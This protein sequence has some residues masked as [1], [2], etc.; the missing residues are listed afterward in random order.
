MT[1]FRYQDLSRNTSLDRQ[2]V[3]NPPERIAGKVNHR[4]DKA[5]IHRLENDVK[6]L[7]RQL[8]ELAA[9]VLKASS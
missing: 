8:K 5:R 1:T 9:I 3:V 4:T 6:Q 2:P 7:Q